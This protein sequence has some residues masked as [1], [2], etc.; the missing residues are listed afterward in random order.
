[1]YRVVCAADP[2]DQKERAAAAAK[3]EV[4]IT[5]F[6]EK[7]LK[8]ETSQAFFAEVAGEIKNG[9]DKAL[10]EVEVLAYYLD[11]KGKPHLIDIAGSN[12]PGQATF[13]KCWPVLAGSS[14]E[15][16]RAPLK[17][18]ESRKFTVDIPQT[19]DNPPDVEPEKFGGRA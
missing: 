4:K 16:A 9:G 3:I 7:V 19:F 18:G 14:L 1:G 2:A 13:S 17:P 10:D 5:G 8:T 6:K 11:E 15:P 12:K